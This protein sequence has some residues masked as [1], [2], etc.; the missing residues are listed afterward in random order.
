MQTQGRGIEPANE[1]RAI[2]IILEKTPTKLECGR[3]N[4]GPQY[5][6]ILIRGINYLTWKR[7][8][9]GAGTNEVAHS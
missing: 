2:D 1:G 4:N 8:S 6:H 5:V 3:Q 9:K 7:E